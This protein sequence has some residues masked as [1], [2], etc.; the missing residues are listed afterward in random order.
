MKITS[1]NVIRCVNLINKQDIFIDDKFA[2]FYFVVKF[3]EE[4]TQ[5][6][7]VYESEGGSSVVIFTVI[8]DIKNFSE[9]LKVD[10]ITNVNRGNQNTKLEELLENVDYF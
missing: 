1:S 7:E 3:F 9:E 8:P 4:I 2:E 5:R 10:F 6:V